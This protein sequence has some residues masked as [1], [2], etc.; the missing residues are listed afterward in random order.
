MPILVINH[1]SPSGTAEKNNGTEQN[2]HHTL[3][4]TCLDKLYL[5]GELECYDRL[6]SHPFFARRAP[7]PSFRAHAMTS[8]ADT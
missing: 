5:R 3:S 4:R 8:S 6:V 2:V 7:F 1:S